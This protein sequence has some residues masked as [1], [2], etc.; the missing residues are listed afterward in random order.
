MANNP[1]ELIKIKKDKILEN[2]KDTSLLYEELGRCVS[3]I[4]KI[5]NFSY[6]D[7]LLTSFSLANEEYIKLKTKQK[8][9]LNIEKNLDSLEK[10]LRNV[11][12]K[13]RENESNLKQVLLKIGAA[14][15]EAYASHTLSSNI[16]SLLSVKF[17]EKQN[18][19]NYL[20]LKY[21]ES[22]SKLFKALIQKILNFKRANLLETFYEAALLLESQSN[23]ETIPMIDKEKVLNKYTEIKHTQSELLY[24]FKIFKGEIDN[25]K[26]DD[27]D[28][29]KTK[30]E[31]LKRLVIQAEDSATNAAILLGSDL[32]EILPDGITSND[33]G[34]TAI[35]LID[36]ITL[37]KRTIEKHNNDIKLLTNEL[38]IEE[39]KSQI[40]MNKSSIKRLKLQIN[41]CNG[42]I[43]T[44]E[45][46]IGEKKFLIDS[47]VL[48]GVY[49]EE[50]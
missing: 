42:E 45:S 23:I 18:K 35:E 8:K 30:L 17:K 34:V 4:A 47:L 43:E 5:K 49:S 11:S 24:S 40:Y 22:K 41:V 28:D 21:K 3:E 31:E 6:C 19:I 37:H 10:E 7:E 20:E 44:I 16:M 2:E 46:S 13:I 15:Y 1:L 26:K 12:K 25:L 48:E 50:R 29:S 36:Q 32:Y 27:V 39:I 38:K 33:I 9:Y 14:S